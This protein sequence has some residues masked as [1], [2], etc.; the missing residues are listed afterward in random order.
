[1]INYKRNDNNEPIVLHCIR[2]YLEGKTEEYHN[3]QVVPTALFIWEGQ[4]MCEEHV[5]K[6]RE[7]YRD[8]IGKVTRVNVEAYAKQKGLEPIQIDGIIEGFTFLED[9]I[10]IG[11]ITYAGKYIAFVPNFPWE[12]GMVKADSVGELL[13]EYGNKL[14]T[15]DGK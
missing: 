12:D 10:T 6:T 8:M 13:Q 15:R 9:A 4:S 3:G 5:K 11:G 7:S 14:K 1:M 2:C